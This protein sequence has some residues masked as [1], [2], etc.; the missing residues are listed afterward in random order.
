MLIPV[1][2]KTHHNTQ[3]PQRRLRSRRLI[4]VTCSLSH[5]VA[6]F[7]TSQ[8]SLGFRAAAS[9]PEYFSIYPQH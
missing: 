1:Y 8:L 7:S 4:K 3:E 9:S 2:L 5:S 6:L